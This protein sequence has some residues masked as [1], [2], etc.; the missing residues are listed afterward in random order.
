[1]GSILDFPGEARPDQRS[2][3][4]VEKLIGKWDTAEQL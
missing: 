3:V 2:V 4:K 1:M